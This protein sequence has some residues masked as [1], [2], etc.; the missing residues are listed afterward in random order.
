MTKK[1][2]PEPV[3]AKFEIEQ[4]DFGRMTGMTLT[5]MKPHISIGVRIAVRFKIVPS[6]SIRYL[7]MRNELLFRYWRKLGAS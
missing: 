7:G 2:L 5:T 4:F 3:N 1:Q 6:D